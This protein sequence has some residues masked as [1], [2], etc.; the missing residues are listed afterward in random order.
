MREKDR[1]I[2]KILLE[3]WFPPVVLVD[4]LNIIIAAGIV[5]PTIESVIPTT[6]HNI[7]YSL[8]CIRQRVF[9]T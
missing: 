5:F 4:P 9:L 8:H 7:E 3:E 1:E 2:R 6:L